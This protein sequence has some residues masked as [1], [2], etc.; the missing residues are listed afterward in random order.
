MKSFFKIGDVYNVINGKSKYRN[1]TT[2]MITDLNKDRY[3][4]VTKELFTTSPDYHCSLLSSRILWPKDVFG[5]HDKIKV[6]ID[7]AIKYTDWGT[8]LTEAVEEGLISS[9]LVKYI[10]RDQSRSFIK[11]DPIIYV[12]ARD[13]NDRVKSNFVLKLTTTKST[14]EHPFSLVFKWDSRSNMQADVRLVYPDAYFM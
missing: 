5:A 4:V 3:E 8:N 2:H 11:T 10:F 14:D 1:I 9:K 13:V 12:G 6:T 7:Q